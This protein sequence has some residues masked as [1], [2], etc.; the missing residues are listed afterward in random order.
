MKNL[1]VLVAQQILLVPHMVFPSQAQFLQ[2]A[3]VEAGKWLER[4]NVGKGVDVT[5][6]EKAKHLLRPVQHR[7]VG[8][9]LVFSD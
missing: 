5:R 6:R 8:W 9:K 1:L 4:G 2:L 3:E 7:L